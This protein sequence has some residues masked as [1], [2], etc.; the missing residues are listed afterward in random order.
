MNE[1]KNQIQQDS[2]EAK[3]TS[4]LP[5]LDEIVLQTIDLYIS[6]K[7]IPAINLQQFQTPIVV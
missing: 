2:E 4:P 3:K 1:L 7:D 5:T 6:K